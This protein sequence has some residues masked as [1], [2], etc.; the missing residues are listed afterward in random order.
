M[1]LKLLIIFVAFAMFCGCTQTDE[2]L[3]GAKSDLA[4]SVGDENEITDPYRVNLSEASR[5]ANQFFSSIMGEKKLSRASDFQ[6]ITDATG[7]PAMYVMNF[8]QGGFIIISAVKDLMPVL[9]YDTENSFD[10]HNEIPG[11]KSWTDRISNL[12]A[13]PSYINPDSAA[14]Y[15]QLWKSFEAVT[16]KDLNP[17]ISRDWKPTPI[18]PAERAIIQKVWMDSMNSWNAKHYTVYGLDELKM[19]HPDKYDEI[20]N[21]VF[22][23]IWPEYQGEYRN[24]T[25]IIE[26]GESTNS[27]AGP[28]LKTTWNQTGGFNQSYPILSN[29]L[30]AYAGCGP[31]AIGQIMFFYKYPQ[32]I[33]WTS[34]PLDY[35]SKTT[36]DFLFSIADFANAKYELNGTSVTRDKYVPIYNHFGYNAKFTDWKLSTAVSEVNNGHPVQISGDIVGTKMGHAYIFDG[37]ESYLGKQFLEVWTFPNYRGFSRVHSELTNITTHVSY[38]YNW[39][40]GGICNGFYSD[41]A[42]IDLGDKG[43]YKHVKMTINIYPK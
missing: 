23:A 16:G 31:V 4:E 18:D 17:I 27:T 33:K 6:T 37:T 21:F 5:A 13:N 30:H 32:S 26:R 40:W 7:N 8:P 36:S 10:L 19:R 3:N 11:V 35:G 20:N 39:G 15:R 34:M 38:H 2:P 42:T 12:T 14:V 1:K 24:F 29:G 9:A 28:L 41:P 22:E 25:A 43:I